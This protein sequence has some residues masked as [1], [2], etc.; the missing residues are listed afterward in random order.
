M[1]MDAFLACAAALLLTGCAAFQFDLQDAISIATVVRAGEEI[2]EEWPAWDDPT[3]AAKTAAFIDDVEKFAQGLPEG[4]NRDKLLQL[5]E[6]ARNAHTTGVTI[7]ALL[8]D[9]GGVETLRAI[10]DGN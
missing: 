2:V 1:R 4:E 5:I 6:E 9:D 3:R 7:Y 8:K 10:R